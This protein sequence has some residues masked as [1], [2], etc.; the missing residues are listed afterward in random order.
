MTY[1]M[2][3]FQALAVIAAPSVDHGAVLV[4][5]GVVVVVVVVVLGAV[6]W[7]SLRL[8]SVDPVLKKGVSSIREER[9]ATEVLREFL[10][11]V[12][13]DPVS[14]PCLV[15]EPAPSSG[16]SSHVGQVLAEV[17]GGGGVLEDFYANTLTAK[18]VR[19]AGPATGTL[20]S[21]G[22]RPELSGGFGESVRE[23]VEGIRDLATAVE[24]AALVGGGSELDR[25]AR[26]VEAFTSGLGAL[27]IKDVLVSASRAAA[28]GPAPDRTTPAK[29]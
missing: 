13:R 29:T 11:D 7:G 12:Q 21:G 26:S 15:L 25:A 6:I 19:T 1:Y 10:P 3:P 27:P 18:P 24:Q 9:F 28:A 16:V 5:V 4:G 2:T 22:T 23:L 17:T 20:T 14:A 8:R